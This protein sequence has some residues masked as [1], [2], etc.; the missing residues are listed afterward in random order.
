MGV[1]DKKFAVTY[2]IP[3]ILNDRRFLPAKGRIDTFV[4]CY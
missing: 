3:V 1:M 4:K 2:T